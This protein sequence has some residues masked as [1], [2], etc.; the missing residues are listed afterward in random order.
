MTPWDAFF[1]GVE[2]GED[3]QGGGRDFLPTENQNGKKTLSFC[4]LMVVLC[5]ATFFF[6]SFLTGC[7]FLKTNSPASI[8]K[9]NPYLSFG[10]TV[11]PTGYFAEEGEEVT[12]IVEAAPDWTL[13]TG[14]SVIYLH[15]TTE[16]TVRVENEVGNIYQFTMPAYDVH[17]YAAFT[18]PAPAA[19]LSAG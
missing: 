18:A 7:K 15:E 13:K 5:G 14:P 6:L 4:T 3:K 17:I 8:F 12:I 10:G 11:I 19:S 9:I 16:K 2:M 1:G